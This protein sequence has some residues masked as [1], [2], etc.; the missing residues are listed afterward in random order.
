M[1]EQAVELSPRA[2]PPL[3][4]VREHRPV[5]AVPVPLEPLLRVIAALEPQKLGKAGVT[6][7][8]LLPR[9]PAVIGQ[10]VAAAISE[11]VVDE[12]AEGGGGARQALGGMGRRAG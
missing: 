7:L 6:G 11:R 12:Q 4:G 9:R 3:Q 1:A 5:V 8:D 10:V 2:I